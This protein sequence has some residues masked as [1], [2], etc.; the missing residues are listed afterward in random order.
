MNSHFESPDSDQRFFAGE[1]KVVFAHDLSG[2]FTFL[3]HAG[4]QIIGYSC[5]E[6]RRLNIADLIRPEIA[7][8]LQEQIASIITKKIGAVYEIEIIAKDGHRVPL[9]VS[10][11]VVARRGQPVEIEGIAVP[12]ILRVEARAKRARCL[13]D[14]FCNT[15]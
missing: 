5:E 1:E 9:E 6:A 3:N 12:S 2:N 11:R 10:L 8:Q 15:I 14:D 7:A 4:E 13:D